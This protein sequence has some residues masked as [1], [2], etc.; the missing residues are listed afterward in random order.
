[1]VRGVGGV[2]R[3][4][5]RLA[6][7]V[8]A[9][10]GMLAFAWAG[11]ARAQ[12]VKYVEPGG[13]GDCSSWA[14]ACGLQAALDSAVSGDEIWVAKGVYKPGSDRT[15][16]F[17]LK[18]GVGVYGGFDGDETLRDERDT[19]PSDT[20]LSGDVGIG[21][22][23]ADNSY[24]VVTAG[25]TSPGT[26]LDGFVVRDGYAS[27]TTFP[28]FVGA[29][30]YNDGGSPTLSN[31]L[32]TGNEAS[33]PT[34]AGAGGGMYNS[35]GGSPRLT[36]VTFLGNRAKIEAAGM[37]NSFGSPTLVNVS[38]LDNGGGSTSSGGG[39]SSS[40]SGS[41]ATLVNVKFSGN[42]TT[43]TGG[44]MTVDTSSTATLTN[45]TF[46][47]NS[48]FNTRVGGGGLYVGDGSS[49]ATVTNGIF[50]GNTVNG[51]ATRPYSQIGTNGGSATVK[52][53]IVQDADPNDASIPFGGTGNSNLDD[54][55]RFIGGLRLG[56]GSPAIDVGDNGAIPSGVSTDL[57]GNRRITNSTVDLGV[58]ERQGNRPPTVED[59]PARANGGEPRQ[60]TLRGTDPDGDGLG[61][62]ISDRPDHGTLGTISRPNCDGNVPSACTA[63]V[64]YTPDA[65]YAGPDSFTYT[66][67]DGATSS[68]RTATVNVT[69]VPVNSRPTAQDGSASMNEDG[70]PISID[71]AAL[72][73]DV[74]TSDA[75]LT[76]TVVSGPAQ[77]TLSGSGATR[78]FAP[79]RDFNGTA[80]FTYKVI[81]RGSPDGC[82]TPDAGCAAPK[83]SETRTVTITVKPVNDAPSFEEGPDQTVSEDAGPQ[84]VPRWATGISSGPADESGQILSFL[85]SNDDDSLFARDGQPALDAGGTLTYTPAPDASGTAT[86]TV[87]LRDDGGTANG[88]VDT[89]AEQGFEIS[90]RAANDAPEVAFDNPP[91]SADEGETETFSFTVTDPDPGDSFDIKSGFPRCGTGGS[92][93]DGS[94]STN[95]TGVSFR[96]LFPDGPA[97]PDVQVQVN[98][99][100]ADSNVAEQP[101]T[102]ANVEP[103]VTLTGPDR[104]EESTTAVRE[105]AFTVTDPGDDTFAAADGSPSCGAKGTLVGNSLVIAANGGS[106]GCFFLVGPATTDVAMKVKD[107]DGAVDTD[108]PTVR[109]TVDNVAPEA[110]DLTLGVDEDSASSLRLPG[111]DPGGDR[112]TFG[113]TRL[114]E[115]GTLSAGGAV[116]GT[117]SNL[118]AADVTYKPNRDYNNTASSPDT[119]GYVVCDDAPV[120]ACDEG[121]V[122]MVVRPVNDPPGAAD[123]SYTTREDTG[124]AL[125]LLSGATDP[126]G[127]RLSIRS[128]TR[129]A[130]GTDRLFRDANGRQ[131]ARYTPNRDYNGPD[132]FSYT[133]CDGGGGAA[134]DTARVSVVV[135]PVNDAPAARDDRY[136]TVEDGRLVVGAGRGVL[137]NDS[138]VDRDRLSARVA[139]GPGH[140]RLTLRA[141]GSFTYTPDRDYAGADS[142]FYRVSDGKGGTGRATVRL[143]VRS[144]PEPGGGRGCTI[145]G[146]RGNDTLRGTPGRDVICAL[147]GN[148]AV[149]GGGGNDIIYGDAGNDALH[150]GAGDDRLVG[151]AGDDDLRGGPG[152]DRLIGGPGKDRQRQ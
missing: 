79:A 64:T 136:A 63:D 135:S 8:V 70:A 67:S 6:L 87:R 47:Y 140:G 2:R 81:D 148:D 138:D 127:D 137:S 124:I 37:Y 20:V 122:S 28:Y 131:K 99:G 76:Y 46:A 84:T 145:T 96:C 106:F 55:P 1:M 93:V 3:G 15:A 54:D 40:G 86:V 43:N 21:G 72:V 149:Y 94:L 123:H 118:P 111:I 130:H 32:I 74:E 95:A 50:W 105:Y 88:G 108:D 12:G 82:G 117:A 100:D 22:Y 126:D 109:V 90:I 4:S 68:D 25:G 77:G 35:G 83:E 56:A 33:A 11:P 13:S 61:F 38:F 44:G 147:G 92:L 113:I 49:R 71:L 112:L 133:L 9:A 89:S 150:G 52:H 75:A 19:N 119:F 139:S 23:K 151:G 144:A 36:N 5:A 31:L 78:T 110:R 14:N 18:D 42:S 7:V 65:A 30:I 101:V 134:C 142:F 58:Y 59:V 51:D 115:N 60:V 97:S 143:A 129:P 91:S 73:S 10:L 17:R 152:R 69:V 85:V 24:N 16:T 128:V 53:S 27:T 116:V 132:R 120:P 103:S 107:S 41:N 114:P 141:D 26:V 98:D 34:S 104:V 125:D 146:T 48:A 62:S 80:T 39:M 45:V 121:A 29:G 57:D 66:A 102:V